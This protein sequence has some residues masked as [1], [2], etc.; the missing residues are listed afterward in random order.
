MSNTSGF[1]SKLPCVDHFFRTP[2]CSRLGSGS[3]YCFIVFQHLFHK[4]SARHSVNTSL[5]LASHRITSVTM[6]L[7]SSVALCPNRNE[8]FSSLS[9]LPHPLFR[10]LDVIPFVLCPGM[11]GGVGGVTHDKTCHSKV[12]ARLPRTPATPG[13]SEL[14]YF[15]WLDSILQGIDCISGCNCHLPCAVWYAKPLCRGLVGHPG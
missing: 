4:S 3:F 12:A 5:V 9:S 13:R 6:S 1:T 11:G 15:R 2:L 7:F 8:V 14:R 10:Y